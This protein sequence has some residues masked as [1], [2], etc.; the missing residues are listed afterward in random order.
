MALEKALVQLATKLK[1]ST[2]EFM[3]YEVRQCMSDILIFATSSVHN[4]ESHC[5]L[6]ISLS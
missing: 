1:E 4:F 2:A 5:A 6:K 3:S